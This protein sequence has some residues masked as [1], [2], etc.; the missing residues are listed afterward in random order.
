MIQKNTFLKKSYVDFLEFQLVCEFET[1][2]FNV[3]AFS[4]GSTK[5][6]INREKILT[7]Y[8]LKKTTKEELQK[9]RKAHAPIFILKDRETLAYCN[10]SYTLSLISKNLGIGFHQCSYNNSI[11]SHLSALPESDGGCAKVMSNL[12]IEDA[13][14][15]TKGFQTS[16]VRFDALFV[17]ECTNCQHIAANKC[18]STKGGNS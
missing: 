15:I 9:I 17:A 11:C 13:D 6:V 1:T 4:F 7:T 3:E 14:F 10:V 18:R 16:Y 2:Y 12:R 5:K 8:P